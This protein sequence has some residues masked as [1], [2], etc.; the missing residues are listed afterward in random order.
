MDRILSATR[1]VILIGVVGLLLAAIAGFV[2]AVIETAQLIAYIGVHAADPEL[3]VQEVNFIKLV[4]GFLISTGLLIFA[5]GLYEIFIHPLNVPEGLKFTTIGQ[6][7]SSL[8]SIIAL[9]LGVTFLAV[10]Q[11]GAEPQSILYIGLAVAAVIITLVFFTRGD[12]RN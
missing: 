9:T 6:L 4:D 10:V 11:E 7:K 12:H 8:A 2:F 1:Y 3:E 5:L